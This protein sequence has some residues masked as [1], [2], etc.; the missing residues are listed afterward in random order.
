MLSRR[1]FLFL[2]T[3][4]MLVTNRANSWATPGSANRQKVGQSVVNAGASPV[5]FINLAKAIV[6]G[7]SQPNWPAGTN[8]DGF[9]ASVAAMGGFNW[10]MAPVVCDPSYYGR[11]YLWWT[12]TGNLQ[13]APAVIVY[14][15][16]ASAANIQPNN[17]GSVNGNCLFGGSS[18]SRQPTSSMPVQFAFGTLIRTVTSNRGLIQFSSQ[19][20]DGFFQS[21]TG[22]KFSFNNLTYNGGPFPAGPNSD[23]SWTVNQDDKNHVSLHGSSSLNPA[24]VGLVTTGGP[25]V[26]SEAIQSTAQVSMTIFA[27]GTISGWSNI[28]WCKARDQAAVLAGQLASP[29][30]IEAM[31]TLNPRFIRFMDFQAIQNDR[32]SAYA[33]RCM[34]SNF[35][36]G[37]LRND[38][39]YYGGPIRNDGSDNYTCSNPATSPSS[40]SYLDGEV[41]HG[42]IKG[43]NFGFNPSLN[44]G[45]R[46][47]A[48]ILS[49]SVN[50][51]AALKSLFLTG[52]VPPV[53]TVQTFNFSGAGLSGTYSPTYKTTSSDTSLTNLG[54]NIATQLRADRTL[55]AAGILVPFGANSFGSAFCFTYNPNQGGL[56]ASPLTASAS[57]AAGGVTY[58]FGTMYNQAG[59][60]LPNGT[61]A[62]FSYSALLGA[63]FC[64][65]S[66]TTQAGFNAGVP[67]E[68]MTDLCNRAGVG[69]YIQIGMMWSV[70][71]IQKTVQYFAQN[72]NGE[73]KIAFSNETWN[74]FEAEWAPCISLAGALG[75][76]NAS[77][78]GYNS[79]SGLR[80][81]QISQ[82]AQAAWAA[83]G[84]P[85]S[86]LHVQLEYWNIDMSARLTSPLGTVQSRLRG[87]LLNPTSNST[88]SD[89]GGIGAVPIATNP[90][91]GERYNYSLFPHR[92]VDLSNEIGG[93]PYFQGAQL[94]AS[95]A[96][97]GLR[98]TD[99]NGK[100]ITAAAYKGLLLA[101]YNHAY[102][103]PTQRS[104]ALDFLYNENSGPG[105]DLYDG[106]L[107]RTRDSA[108]SLFL[109]ETTGVTG[110]AGIF[111]V[112]QQ[113][114]SYD[115]QRASAGLGQLGYCCY[116]G[117]MGVGP[118]TA[119]DASAIASSLTAL[120][121][122]NGYSSS[123]SGAASG[124][125][126]G[127][128]DTAASASTNIQKL[129][130]AFKNDN[131][132][133][134]LTKRYL[135]ICKN[136]GQWNGSSFVDR[137]AFGTHFGFD[138]PDVWSFYPAPVLSTPYKSFD[139]YHEW[140]NE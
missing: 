95:Q 74:L 84:R 55:Q 78:I 125:P 46:G 85:R 108:S 135:Q 16:G 121:Y 68:F 139:A 134:L 104:A 36:W 65:L 3:V 86:E 72:L 38:P 115:S 106:T 37:P 70:D 77:E 75:I 100:S 101:A 31:K 130:A 112:G 33:A 97:S 5:A 6:P 89:F 17:S 42:Q 109:W 127:S 140:N 117:D 126:S 41:V 69:C 60:N 90:T 128:S 99:Y 12:G 35:S 94:N 71:R 88:L 81:A 136:A 131:R 25:G 105:G 122:T 21:P 9:P 10:H 50:A 114:A 91:T 24:L 47:A 18:P 4:A 92:P 34:P 63:W 80:T 45:G 53:G 102:G 48:P 93:A 76:T 83:V 82:I 8:S 27:G 67:L 133:Q 137:I 73:L 30:Y 28:V 66:N 32:T 2:S 19:I 11:Y 87:E 40:G 132:Y 1:K 124:G 43:A 7:S 22:T 29:D 26:Q 39:S 118:I 58:S 54:N 116:E 20:L 138:G 129:L 79:F 113:I 98:A 119:G 123:L 13:L 107:N 52:N 49:T 96:N 15:G 111:G 110:A 62:Y 14:S 120:G 61:Y 51:G 23:G 59:A 57:D 64:C 56:G 44:V 103:T